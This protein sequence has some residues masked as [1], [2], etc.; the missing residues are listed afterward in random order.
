M[1]DARVDKGSK[2]KAET[3]NY[4]ALAHIGLR[5]RTEDG[6]VRFADA[7]LLGGLTSILKTNTQTAEQLADRLGI[8]TEEV[9]FCIGLLRGSGVDVESI[10]PEDGSEA[11]YFI[12]VV[13]ADGKAEGKV[14][15]ISGPDGKERTLRIGFA[16]DFHFG[17]AFHLSRSFHE[18]MSEL[19]RLKINP[20]YVAGD[21][22]DGI[23]IYNGQ[24]FDLLKTD[25]EGQIDIAAAALARHPRLEFW[26]IGGNHDVSFEKGRVNPLAMLEEKVDNFKNLGDISADVISHGITIRLLHGG[27]KRAATY[28]PDYPGQELAGLV[29]PLHEAGC[30]GIRVPHLLLLGHYHALYYGE[31]RGVYVMQPGCFMGSGKRSVGQSSANPPVGAFIVQLCYSNAEINGMNATYIM[32][33]TSTWNADSSSVGTRANCSL[34]QEEGCQT[35]RKSARRDKRSSKADAISESLDVWR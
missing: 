4:S 1:E 8:T 27:R 20:V 25:V 35:S 14:H 3:V 31:D 7:G 21:I 15:F 26:G 12:K 32:P 30:D 19:E 11:S 24:E 2:H 28:V 22:V 29:D 13:T 9:G 33:H 23:G 18:V 34:N 16:S 6:E 5:S 17:S 10:K